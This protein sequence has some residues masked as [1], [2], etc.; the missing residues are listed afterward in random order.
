[1]Q[2]LQLTA[3]LD[4]QPLNKRAPPFLV[5]LERVRLPAAAVEGK[6]QLAAQP[7]A[8]RML[9]H[10]PVEVADELGAASELE[11]GGDPPLEREQ[12]S[13]LEPLRLGGRERRVLKIRERASTPKAKRLAQAVV[14][15]RRVACRRGSAPLLEQRLEP[16][17]IQ[18]A[19][20]DSDHIAGRSALDPV[21]ANRSTQAGD[22]IVECVAGAGRRRC[23]PQPIDQSIARDRLVGIE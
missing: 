11:L 2:L 4:T 7:L 6:H 15:A 14:C 1:M 5:G 21:C 22:V 10:E 3:R 13:L 8:E 17:E 18:F 20:I 12:P 16:F 9:G 19:R 23:A